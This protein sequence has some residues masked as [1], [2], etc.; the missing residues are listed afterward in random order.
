VGAAEDVNS[1]KR[2]PAAATDKPNDALDDAVDVLRIKLAVPQRP[3]AL[4]GNF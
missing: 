3:G 4:L 2:G 1:A